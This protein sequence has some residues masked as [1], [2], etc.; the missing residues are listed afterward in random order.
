M[1]SSTKLLFP[2]L[3]LFLVQGCSGAG[4]QF[5]A[6]LASPVM[7]SPPSIDTT[8]LIPQ[9]RMTVWTPGVPG[10][11]PSYSHIFAVIDASTFGNGTTNASGAINTAIASARAVASAEN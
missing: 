9:D 3:T 10:G 1:R 2:I 4:G 5:E 7:V 11:I 8:G 6:P